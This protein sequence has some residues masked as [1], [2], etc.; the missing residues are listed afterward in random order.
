M[1]CAICRE[2]VVAMVSEWYVEAANHTCG[3]YDSS[4]D[5]MQLAGLSP[6]PASKVP[7]WAAGDAALRCTGTCSACWAPRHVL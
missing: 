3:P 5:E 6:Q 4:V 2:F 7:R 1:R